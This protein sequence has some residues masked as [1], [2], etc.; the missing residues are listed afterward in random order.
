MQHL[1]ASVLI[2]GPS[3]LV[4][5]YQIPAGLPARPGCRVRVPLR[6]RPASGTVL[7]VQ[8]YEPRNLDYD[9]RPLSSLI[10]PEPLI[11]PTLLKL[12]HWI[13]DYYTAPLEQVMR[14]LLPE[15]VRQENTREKTQ[16][17]LEIAR[18]PEADELATRQKRA[19][20]Q[21][22]ILTLL[23]VASEPVPLA[24]LPGSPAASVKA[25]IEKGL[26]RKTT[27]TLR[28]DPDASETF[29]PTSPLTLNP[30]QSSVL[31]TIKNSLATPAGESRP[32]ILLHGITGAGKTEVYLQATQAALDLGQNVLILLPEIS[33]APQTVQRFKSRFAASQIEIAVLHSYLSQGERFDEWHRIRKGTARVVIGARSALFAPVQKLGLTIVD[34]EHETA[35]KQDNPPK[36]HARD[37]AIVRAHL[38]KSTILLGSATPSLESYHNSQSGKYQL[39]ELTQRADGAT[40][41]LTRIIDMRI[42]ARKHKGSPAILSD[43][44]RQAI[45]K[46]LEKDEQ[47]I[48]FLNRR[49]FARAL[50]CPPCGHTIEC[51]HCAIALTYHRSA[52]RLICHLCGHQAIVPRVCPECQDPAIRLQGYGT[53]KAEEVLRKVFPQARLARL[54][55]DTAR[56][57]N[58][59]RDTLRDFRAKKIDLLLGTQ[60]IAKGLDFPNVTLVGVLNADLSLHAPDFR[61]G[62]RT[63]QLLTQVS[64]RA[65]RGQMAGEVIIQTA[66]PHAP[67]I[68]YARQ[69]D[70]HGFAEQELAMRRDFAYPPYGHLALILARSTHERRAEF[71]LQTLH[72][73][74]AEGLPAGVE[75]G[76]PLPSPLTR[77]HGQFRFQ[78]ILRGPKAR[79]LSRHIGQV[80][81]NTP[82]PEDV[83]VTADI[84]ALDLG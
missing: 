82:T 1:R 9:L 3:E 68:Q 63:F 34:E 33:L 11:T 83:I 8:A 75:L 64:G 29:L 53:E 51:P 60:M 59:L 35:Y 69:H 80:L 12:A 19:K 42:E 10:D 44:L 27:L 65:G 18:P 2:D 58:A 50:Q 32:P 25:L 43:I 6:N 61:A 79:P 49:G 73:R 71:T 31:Q 76:E 47:V 56:R 26:I 81:K 70:F 17:A 5:D 45:E 24:K 48:L 54:D 57:K 23:Q 72:R 84:D 20:R 36:Y 62:E 77:S 78:L 52:E 7:D 30:E 66:T 14:A 39:A 4:F 21:A 15:A 41:P 16:I 55:T 67:A 22:E 46:R 28:R 38:E 37:L 74:L 40:L 13:A